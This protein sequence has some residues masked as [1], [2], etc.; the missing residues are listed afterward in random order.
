[1][2]TYSLLSFVRFYLNL[3]PLWHQGE[4]ISVF[5]FNFVDKSDWNRKVYSYSLLSDVNWFLSLDQMV[6]SIKQSS[7][8]C[9]K[10]EDAFDAKC[11]FSLF[12][13]LHIS[14]SSSKVAQPKNWILTKKINKKLF[15]SKLQ[16]SLSLIT[17]TFKT[18]T[19][20]YK[21]I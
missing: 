21:R 2:Y 3:I 13:S 15:F 1:M 11:K 6:S 7:I 18:W 19:L 16:I 5:L 17:L 10:T 4:G 9:Q 20:S 12:V 8:Y 14:S